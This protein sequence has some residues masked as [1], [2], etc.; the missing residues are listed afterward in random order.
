MF[1]NC[2]DAKLLDIADALGQ[3]RIIGEGAPAVL[4]AARPW[5][6]V[7]VFHPH[8]HAAGLG[9]I[10]AAPCHLDA[11]QPVAA[12]VERSRG[13]RPKHPLIAHH[14]IEV[15]VERVEVEGEL[16]GGVRAIKE[17]VCALFVSQARH[18][19][20][21]QGCAAVRGDMADRDQL[22]AVGQHRAIGTQ[23]LVGVIRDGD[24]THLQPVAAHNVHQ[25]DQQRGMLLVG[26]NDLIPRLPC[27]PLDDDVHRGR[28]L[29]GEGD[30]V[31]VCADELRQRGPRPLDAQ[32]FII[33]REHLGRPVGDDRLRHAQQFCA[34]RI[35]EG[36]NTTTVKVGAIRQHRK[37]AAN[38]A[39][40][41]GLLCC[42]LIAHNLTY[43]PMA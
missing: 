32:K 11:I 6:P 37:I 16:S 12:N 26:D 31:G 3:R 5:N 34:D 23:H 7:Q 42:L 2:L 24:A 10:A 8:R 27:H 19:L 17:D 9:D 35:G 41:P 1:G 39:D 28:E 15:T 43:H 40:G 22:G 14:G 21:R 20:S 4:E 30:L 18:F 25:R 38:A 29:G 36:R 13:I 33:A